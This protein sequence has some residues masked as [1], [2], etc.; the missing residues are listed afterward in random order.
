MSPASN[1]KRTPFSERL[2][3]PRS[4]STRIVI[5]CNFKKELIL[6]EKKCLSEFQEEKKV[7]VWLFDKG[8][9]HDNHHLWAAK[10]LSLV[11]KLRNRC[12][13]GIDY[14][15]D[16]IDDIIVD[17]DDNDEGLL[18]SSHFGPVKEVIP[19]SHIA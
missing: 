8:D 7:F 1:L 14:D 11:G 13:L 10:S 4:C 5:K 19:Q 9:N 16:D 6:N 2:L 15:V 18:P 3:T 17:N 12:V